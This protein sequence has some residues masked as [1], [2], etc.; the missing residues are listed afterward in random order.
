MGPGADSARFLQALRDLT[1]AQRRA[2]DLRRSD[3]RLP[4]LAR[5]CP[6]VLCIKPDLTTL[7]KILAGGLPGGAVVGRRDI[8]DQLDFAQA[9]PP[10]AKRSR[11][12]ARSTP[13]RCRPPPA[14]PRWSCSLRPTPAS[15]PTTMPPVARGAESRAPRRDVPWIVYGTFS[16]F[17][18]FTDPEQR[19]PRAADIESGKLDYRVSQD[20]AAA[21]AGR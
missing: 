12:T 10:D 9:Q 19:R 16:G 1:R 6:G 13:T 17:H 11:T 14:S 8:M 5:R 2:A 18:I 20:A 4:L 7:A 15:G 21:L 3:H